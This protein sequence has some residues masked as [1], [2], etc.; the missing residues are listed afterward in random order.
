LKYHTAVIRIDTLLAA[1]VPVQPNSITLLT[2]CGCFGLI[3]EASTRTFH[4]AIMAS[5]TLTV[6]GATTPD[7]GKGLEGPIQAFSDSQCL[8]LQ[9]Q[10]PREED[11]NACDYVEYDQR[12]GIEGM[13][14]HPVVMMR[15]AGA[16]LWDISGKRY[17]DLLSAFSAANQGHCHPRIVNAVVEQTRKLMIPGRAVHTI[18]YTMLCK[19]LCE[20]G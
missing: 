4:P 5:T 10:R 1:V 19:R 14:A 9:T 11:L 8:P 3:C 15:A 12:F 20:V 6:Q 18:E 2:I 13:P 7:C 16:Y 17:I